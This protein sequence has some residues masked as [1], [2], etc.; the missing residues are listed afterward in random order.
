MGRTAD[1]STAPARTFRDLLLGGCRHKAQVSGPARSCSLSLSRISGI[2][3][4]LNAGEGTATGTRRV[5]TPLR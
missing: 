5:P 4:S 1:A 2:M 3:V